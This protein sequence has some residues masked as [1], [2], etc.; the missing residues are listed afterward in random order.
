MRVGPSAN[1]RLLQ[2]GANSTRFAKPVAGVISNH[3]QG[4]FVAL[5]KLR[6]DGAQLRQEPRAAAGGTNGTVRPIGP[7]AV[8]ALPDL[9][10]DSAHD[11][12]VARQTFLQSDKRQ[13]DSQDG[14]PFA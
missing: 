11:H 10:F 13:V 14:A 8:R 12:G 2:Q 7:A 3:F 9:F 4:D 6:Q 5:H 1:L